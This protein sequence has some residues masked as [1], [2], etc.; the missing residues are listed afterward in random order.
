M[1][2]NTLPYLSQINLR[3]LD[4]SPAHMEPRCRYTAKH[5]VR[6]LTSRG[7]SGA[8]SIFELYEVSPYMAPSLS[9]RRNKATS[10]HS[11]LLA[12]RANEKEDDGDDDAFC[13]VCGSLDPWSLGSTRRFSQAIVAKTPVYTRW[14]SGSALQHAA[15]RG[16]LGCSLLCCPLR[17]FSVHYFGDSDGW[18]AQEEYKIRITGDR[19]GEPESI[20][21]FVTIETQK[22]KRV[23]LFLENDS[24]LQFKLRSPP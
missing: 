12:P 23:Q 22:K 7:R 18:A 10:S 6:G 14:V 4:Y 5:F 2:L 15:V 3:F 17:H 1:F 16:C 24:G 21:P 19:P 13:P 11:A 9:N 8:K 20:S